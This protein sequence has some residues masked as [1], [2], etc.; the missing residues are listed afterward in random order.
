LR[1]FGSFTLSSR[2]LLRLET[3]F[4][5]NNPGLVVTPVPSAHGTASLLFNVTFDLGQ[6]SGTFT[7]TATAGPFS[8]STP[9]VV[10][11]C[12]NGA[13]PALSV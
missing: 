12:G 3:T 10:Q 13:V 4:T 1:R 5:T 9:I 6:S 11:D 2:L 8:A 7:V